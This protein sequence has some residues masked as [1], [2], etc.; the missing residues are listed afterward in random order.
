MISCEI[1]VISEEKGEKFYTLLVFLLG[2]LPKTIGLLGFSHFVCVSSSL[3]RKDEEMVA[4]RK[5]KRRS[6]QER[7]EEKEKGAE[8]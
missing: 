4:K 6:E 1:L 7:A 2:I 3:A 8:R 5:K